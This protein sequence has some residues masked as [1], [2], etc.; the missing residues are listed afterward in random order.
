MLMPQDPTPCPSCQQTIF[1]GFVGSEYAD[2]IVIIPL[3]ENER[4]WTDGLTDSESVDPGRALPTHGE[5][6]AKCPRCSALFPDHFVPWENRQPNQEPPREL[7]LRY[8]DADIEESSG[9][10]LLLASMEET[11]DYLEFLNGEQMLHYWEA[12]TATQQLIYLGVQRIRT[13]GKLDAGIELRVQRLVKIMAQSLSGAMEGAFASRTMLDEKSR[14]GEMPEW[15]IFADMFRL[16]GDFRLASQYLD[17]AFV[18]LE[19]EKQESEMG[20]FFEF[21]AVTEDRFKVKAAR[22]KLIA[23]L[24][25]EGDSSWTSSAFVLREQDS[26]HSR[27]KN[28]QEPA[29]EK[30]QKVYTFYIND[31]DAEIGVFG[32]VAQSADAVEEELIALGYR[33]YFLFEERDLLPE[34]LP[35]SADF[36]IKLSPHLGPQWMPVVDALELVIRDPRSKFF[37]IQTLAKVFNFNPSDSPFIQ[38][39]VLPEG[40]FHLEAPKNFFENEVLDRKKLEQM[41]FIGWNEPGDTEATYNFWRVFDFGWNPRAIAEFTLETLTTVFGITDQD[42][43]DFGAT[44][45]PEEIWKLRNLHRVKKH[46]GNP[47]GSIFHIP[48]DKYK[49]SDYKEHESG[50]ESATGTECE[51][52]TEDHAAPESESTLSNKDKYRKLLSD[53]SELY[54]SLE[55]HRVLEKIQEARSLDEN[56]EYRKSI[57][58]TKE[59]LTI[60]EKLDY[61]NLSENFTLVSDDLYA[62]LKTLVD[63]M[64]DPFGN[65]EAL[66][67]SELPKNLQHLIKEM[68]ER[69][70][71]KFEDDGELHVATLR[72]FMT[73]T[74]AMNENAIQ[75][76]M[77]K[78]LRLLVD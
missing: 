37:C 54:E 70:E 24:I 27:P 2:N 71:N 4:V 8:L 55:T 56:G 22:I 36:R 39:M 62:N 53:L 58:A 23:D 76:E 15:V 11:A 1:R 20:G 66:K 26:E 32:K 78:L 44:W 69:V 13:H 42:F 45:Q 9:D 34:E 43:F 38:G 19:Q 65:K 10:M 46:E 50:A 7:V 40:R 12:W 67:F 25:D 3:A 72:V 51:T 28:L 60:L 41:L 29:G 31:P 68:V 77:A 57:V 63:S 21:A 35:E 74:G 49:I 33:D 18:E 16:A 64:P 14:I 59:L 30:R 5:F 6:I 52:A 73:D 47:K 17:Y 61:E 75:K 48:D